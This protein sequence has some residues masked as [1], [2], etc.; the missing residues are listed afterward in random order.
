MKKRV[1]T[2]VIFILLAV[3]LFAACSSPAI[4]EPPIADPTP[5]P[6]GDGT[7]PAPTPSPE[8]EWLSLDEIQGRAGIYIK[9]GD[10]FL[11]LQSIPFAEVGDL[12]IFRLSDEFSYLL[13]GDRLVHVDIQPRINR[14]SFQFYAAGMS[15]ETSAGAMSRLWEL[16]ENSRGGYFFETWGVNG[17][18]IE[19]EGG[20][21]NQLQQYFHTWMDGQGA[22]IRHTLTGPPNQRFTLGRWRGT[23]WEE[24]EVYMNRR[25]FERVE[26]VEYTYE[27]TLNGYFYLNFPSQSRGMFQISWS[28]NSTIIEIR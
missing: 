23:N 25:V 6:A 2:V 5:P 24:W 4:P 20:I 15:D 14:I 27:R 8:S 22:W 11:P 3:L 16:L 13:A 1:V 28:N 17:V 9:R 7:A 21:P 12:L 10:Q 26:S 19:R 18:E